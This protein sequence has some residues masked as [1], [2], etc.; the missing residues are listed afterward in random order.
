MPSLLAASVISSLPKTMRVPR[1]V[2]AGKI[3]FGETLV[4]EPGP[5]QLLVK[6]G[7]NALCGEEREQY[8]SGT[9]ITPG[10][11][12][13][14]V[15]VA[16]GDG[17]R[18]PVGTR[19]VIYLMDFCGECRSCRAGATNQ[20]QAKRAEMGFN[21]DGGYA[22]YEVV[23][24]RIF[25][26]VDADIP[27]ADATLLLDAMGTGGH[28]VRR[29]LAL[30]Q[31]IE[32][33][34]VSGAGP[35]GLGVAAMCRLLLGEDVHVAVADVSGYRLALAQTL[36][37][38]V[39]DLREE[40]VSEGLVRNGMA[41]VDVAIDTAGKAAARVEGL[42]ALAPRGVLVCV[43]HG[44]ALS[45]D[46]SPELIAPERAVLGSDYFP[47]ADLAAN[48]ALYRSHRDYIGRIITHRYNVSEIQTAFETFFSRQAGKVI[49][50]Q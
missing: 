4:P 29:A 3:V 40:T 38:C 34:L 47:F 41:R 44:E 42:L 8:E 24:E 19:G 21:R 13:A 5:G 22:P 27:L 43:G 20:C 11:E 37:A 39:V 17:T 46:V 12:T 30:R 16:A 26:P 35:V 28:A 33:V 31:D 1:F 45:I 6:V 18:T 50:E 49:V 23:S 9:D 14:G 25:F 2:G 48:L 36:C 15:V 10:H 32:T 7:A